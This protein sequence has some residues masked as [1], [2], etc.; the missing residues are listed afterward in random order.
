M[1]PV[2][3]LPQ[4]W[5]ESVI[6]ILRKGSS[7]HIR[8]TLRAQMDWSPFGLPYQACEFLVRALGRSGLWGERITGMLPLPGAPKSRKP[9]TVFAFLCNHPLALVTP[10]YAKIGLHD[11]HL[12]I[13][14]FSLHIDLTGD[15]SK[16]IAR[17]QTKRT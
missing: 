10:L 2:E 8:W 5:C 16:R 15:L 4:D 17:A 14:L 9:P 3:P 1:N 11:D 12:S 6:R 13:D 7:A